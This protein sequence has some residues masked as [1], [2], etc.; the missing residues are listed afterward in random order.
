MSLK[1]TKSVSSACA[2]GMIKPLFCV[3]WVA[4]RPFRGLLI[5][6][7]LQAL[8]CGVYRGTKIFSVVK[9]DPKTVLLHQVMDISSQKSFVTIYSSSGSNNEIKH[10]KKLIEP[11]HYIPYLLMTYDHLL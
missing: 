6:K 4:Q 11:M 7:V 9:I 1:A 10:N 2:F 5:G 8:T 3:F